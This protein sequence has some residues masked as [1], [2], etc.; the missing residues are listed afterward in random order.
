MF[1]E[2]RLKRE[3]PDCQVATLFGSMCEGHGHSWSHGASK[4]T[5]KPHHD[6]VKEKSTWSHD[7]PRHMCGEG[8]TWKGH[9]F[10]TFVFIW[11]YVPCESFALIRSLR[12]GSVIWSARSVSLTHMS[13]LNKYNVLNHKSSSVLIVVSNVIFFPYNRTIFKCSKHIRIPL[14]LGF[15]WKWKRGDNAFNSLGINDGN[16][17]LRTSVLTDMK[18]L[19]RI[20]QVSWQ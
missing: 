14:L 10:F 4:Q 11:V 12:C 6:I 16:N 20:L 19:A 15:Q 1:I 17:F 7:F 3:P 8:G 2:E 13:H 18:G 9:V 5:S